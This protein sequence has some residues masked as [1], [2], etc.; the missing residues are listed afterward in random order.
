MPIWDVPIRLFHWLLVVAV[1]GAVITGLVGGNLMPWHGRFGACVLGLIVFRLVWGVLGSPTARFREFVRGPAA[2]RAYLRGE[3]R[4]A[5]HNPLGALSVLAMLLMIG[6]QAV[7]G[8]FA[9]D[10]IAFA[11]PLAQLIGTTASDRVTTLHRLGANAALALVALHVAAIAFYTLV[12][13]Q[14]LV[15]AML[16]GGRGDAPLP[17]LAPRTPVGRLLALVF[18]LGLAAAVVWAFQGGF[19]TPPPAAVADPAFD[20]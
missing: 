12:K 15:V 10:D 14:N 5:G 11:G 8:H 4:G 18:A 13:K 6:A 3:W 19:I 7:S 1:C 17:R 2:I 9:R 20:W 16:T